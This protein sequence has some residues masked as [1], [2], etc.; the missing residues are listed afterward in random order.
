MLDVVK[1]KVWCVK[2]GMEPDVTFRHL[3]KRKRKKLR[4]D[5]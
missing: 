5:D 1:E 3:I 4:A 2:F